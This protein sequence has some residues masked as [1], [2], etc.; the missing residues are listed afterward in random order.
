MGR[1]WCHGSLKVIGSRG[2]LGRAR[3]TPPSKIA[4]TRITIP[5][6]RKMRQ[7]R[8]MGESSEENENGGENYGTGLIIQPIEGNTLTATSPNG[9]ATRWHGG[10]TGPPLHLPA[11]GNFKRLFVGL[12]PDDN[13]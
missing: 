7:R 5:I 11:I 8:C 13:N 2:P 1:S 3:Y 6:T 12:C 4:I 10:H 9:G